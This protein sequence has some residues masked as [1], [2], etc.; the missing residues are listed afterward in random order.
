[1]IL[2]SIT[3]CLLVLNKWIWPEAALKLSTS[4]CKFHIHSNGQTQFII[5]GF[6]WRASDSS[7]DE[8]QHF[9]TCSKPKGLRQACSSYLSALL[10]LNNLHGPQN[11]VNIYVSMY[12]RRRPTELWSNVSFIYD[13]PLTQLT[14]ASNQA[15]GNHMSSWVFASE[16]STASCMGAKTFVR[17]SPPTMTYLSNCPQLFTSLLHIALT[18]VKFLSLYST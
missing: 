15:G 14:E 11:P 5:T 7:S 16:L 8:S 10:P 3:I 17:L 2:S 18:E 6:L 13:L 12:I 1:M 9:Q 4:A